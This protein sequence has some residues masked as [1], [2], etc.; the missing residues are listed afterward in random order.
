MI[1]AENYGKITENLRRW[2]GQASPDRGVLLIF[3][4][5]GGVFWLT[6]PP[7]GHVW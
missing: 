4:M 3:S 6:P 7:I 2:G 5:T 1:K